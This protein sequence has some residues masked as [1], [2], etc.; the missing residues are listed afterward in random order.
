MGLTC[1]SRKQTL[2]LRREVRAND[3][4]GVLCGD[5]LQFA[6]NICWEG[7]QMDRQN[8]RQ[9]EEGRLNQILKRN[10]SGLSI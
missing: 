6:K 8:G 1:Q 2:E 5:M 4:W 10:I 3:D 7:E 9:E